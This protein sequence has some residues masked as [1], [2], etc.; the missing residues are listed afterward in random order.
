MEE[1][2]RRA[3]PPFLTG[4]GTALSRANG[5]ASDDARTA[6]KPRRFSA[7]HPPLCGRVPLRQSRTRLAGRGSGLNSPPVD[8][9]CGELPHLSK[10]GLSGP[11]VRQTSLVPRRTSLWRGSRVAPPTLRKR[12]G[13]GSLTCGGLRKSRERE[14]LRRDAPFRAHPRRARSPTHWQRARMSGG[15]GT[16]QSLHILHR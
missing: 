4:K 1:G 14:I 7:I 16:P 5:C 6:D 8:H 9:R 11:P 2:L 13:W 12:E 10:R 3:G 15:P